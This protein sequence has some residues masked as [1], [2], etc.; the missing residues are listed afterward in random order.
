MLDVI[1][2][3]MGAI[4]CAIN[5]VADFMK[6]ARTRDWR[7]ACFGFTNLLVAAFL[8]YEV[9]HTSSSLPLADTP[10]SFPMFVLMCIFLPLVLLSLREEW[11][12]RKQ[13]RPSSSV[14][15]T[16]PHDQ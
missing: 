2:F 5:A 12:A 9:I 3:L 15:Q 16:A 8:F 7:D 11:R 10:I 6:A 14:D 1:T 13:V 4:I